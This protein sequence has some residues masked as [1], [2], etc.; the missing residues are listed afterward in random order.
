MR[1]KKHFFFFFNEMRPLLE[2]ENSDNKWLRPQS[3]PGV[4]RKVQECLLTPSLE[5]RPG[6]EGLWFGGCGAEFLSQGLGCQ[7]PST[8]CRF[9]CRTLEEVPRAGLNLEYSDECGVSSVKCHSPEH[10][11]RLC[12]RCL[13]IIL[14]VDRVFAMVKTDFLV[15]GFTQNLGQKPKSTSRTECRNVFG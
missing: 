8:A 4:I 3:S 2:P 7:H 1:G 15:Q 12:C 6:R 11:S 14:N 9:P 5:N 10:L 13:S